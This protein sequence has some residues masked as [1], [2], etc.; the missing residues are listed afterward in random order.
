MRQERLM[1]SG[2]PAAGFGS[3]DCD[4]HNAVDDIAEL[5]P[6]LPQRWSDYC[7]EHGVTS[8]APAFYPGRAALSATPESRSSGRAPGADPELVR[9]QVLER[10]VDVAILNC[11]YAVQPIHNEDWAV[12]MASALNDWQAQRWLAADPRYRASIVVPSQ[13]PQRAAQEIERLA[14]HGGFVQVLLLANS[15]VPLGNRAH[16]PIYEAAAAAGLPVG[17]HPGVAGGNPPLP[18]GWPSTYLEEYAGAAL[19]MQSQLTSLVCEGVFSRFPALKVVLLE[20][21]V[22]WLPSLMWRLDKNWKGL[23]REI[24]WVAD[25][26]SVVIRR[27]VRLSTAP[28]DGPLATEQARDH[29][30]RF[31]DQL[32]SVDMLLY[33]GD[34]PHWHH[35]DPEQSLLQ[36]LS[37]AERRQVLRDNGLATYPTILQGAAV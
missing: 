19:A 26:P 27:H 24:P 21:G 16:W 14:G 1:S 8:L 25:R 32:G 30:P 7:V 29:L 17:V 28:F 3:I 36:F 18:V 15:Q 4:V 13:N 31:L 5:F 35:R 10:G 12:A 2:T 9:A 23:R 11:L 34:H 20:S 37:P 22:T 33:S 6:Y